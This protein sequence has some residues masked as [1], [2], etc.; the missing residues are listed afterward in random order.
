MPSYM[1]DEGGERTHVVLPVDEYEQLKKSEARLESV[2]GYAMEMISAMGQE[3][4]N[5]SREAT[6]PEQSEAAEEH[7]EH[8]EHREQAWYRSS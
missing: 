3:E 5:E 2:R 4:Q 1:V 8:H 7:H 6:V